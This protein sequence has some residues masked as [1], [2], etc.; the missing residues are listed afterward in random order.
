VTT[1]TS[2]PAGSPVLSKP[3]QEPEEHERFTKLTK[4]LLG[5][6][7]EELDEKRKQDA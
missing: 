2:N 4:A 7:K 3:D 1:E 6:S 5:V